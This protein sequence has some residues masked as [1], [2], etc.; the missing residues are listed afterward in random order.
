MWGLLELLWQAGKDGATM[1]VMQAANAERDGDAAK[2]ATLQEAAEV[3]DAQA[4]QDA[5]TIEYIQGSGM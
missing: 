5:A 1:L 3:L 2:A 4:D